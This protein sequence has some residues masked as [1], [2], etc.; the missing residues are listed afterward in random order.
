M[1]K[2]HELLQFFTYAHLPE[3]LQAV[4]KPFCELAEKLARMT[5]DARRGTDWS[6]GYLDVRELRERV[7]GK[8]TMSDVP[9]PRLVPPNSQAEWCEQKLNE[10]EDSVIERRGLDDVLQSV[11]EAKDCAVRAVLFKA[12]G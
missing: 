11:L 8:R 3:H 9:V 12:E 2:R 10:A 4:S 5:P 6:G 1:S 7:R